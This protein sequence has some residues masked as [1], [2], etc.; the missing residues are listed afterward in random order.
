MQMRMKEAKKGMGHS[1]SEQEDGEEDEVWVNEEG[2]GGVQGFKEGGSERVDGGNT[3]VW[4]V[5]F[6]TRLAKHRNTAC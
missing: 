6:R 1:D 4:P 3:G 5:C 2:T